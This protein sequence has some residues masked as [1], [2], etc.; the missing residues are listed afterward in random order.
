LIG[1]DAVEVGGWIVLPASLRQSIGLLDQLTFLEIDTHLKP[2]DLAV[3]FCLAQRRHSTELGEHD[4]HI[5]L[6]RYGR[7]D[8]N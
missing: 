2:S 8:R 3:S 7:Y 6:L 4:A 5:T 1:S